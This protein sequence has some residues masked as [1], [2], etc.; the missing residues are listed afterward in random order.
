MNQTEAATRT[1]TRSQAV[2]H[3]CGHSGSHEVFPVREMMQGLR[4]VFDYT[5]CPSC[6]SLQLASPPADL[7]KY[8][9]DNYYSFNVQA[10]P[11]YSRV[12]RWLK[13]ARARHGMGKPNLVGAVMVRL[14]GKWP[15]FE[16]F[17]KAG[18]TFQS[19]I[20]DV[21]CGKGDHLLRL[22]SDGF[23]ALAGADPFVPEDFSPVDGVRIHKKTVHEMEGSFDCVF[24]SHSFE[25]MPD[26]QGD[27]KRMGQLVT[28]GG[29]VLIVVPVAD[30]WAWQQYGVNW[31]QID[32]PRHVS[33]PS[34]R[35]MEILAA[36]AGLVLESAIYCSTESQMVFS[37]FY[38]RDIPL[39]EATPEL[40]AKHYSA[41]AIAALHTQSLALNAEGRGD[42]ACFILRKPR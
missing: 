40:V 16:W 18:L 12:E 37:E 35:G 38:A 11:R 22:A 21:G 10:K 9:A 23:T 13:H 14:K 15:Y 34:H 26:P 20:L 31:F 17:Q 25:H 7:S 19:R 8:Y 24:S 1:S 27:L 42:Q 29:V 30:C 5:R 32:A 6:G 3:L 4:E 41:E 33:V 36:G 39:V 28:G 2:C